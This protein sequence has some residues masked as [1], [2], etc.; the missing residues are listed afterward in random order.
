MHRWS[1]MTSSGPQEPLYDQ[2]HQSPVLFQFC[3]SFIRIFS[4][5]TCFQHILVHIKQNDLFMERPKQITKPDGKIF[6]NLVMHLCMVA[7]QVHNWFKSPE[8][9]K[10][11]HSSFSFTLFLNNISLESNQ[12]WWFWKCLDS[13]MLKRSENLLQKCIVTSHE[14]Y[15]LSIQTSYVSSYIPITQLHIS[16]T[17]Q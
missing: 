1:H 2:Q 10:Q 14:L 11:K 17:I 9:N 4:V 12:I 16:I 15:F 3:V 5:W 6:A 7:Y 13:I 8:I